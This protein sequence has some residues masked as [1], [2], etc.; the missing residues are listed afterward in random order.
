MLIHNLEEQL[1][2]LKKHAF[3][4]SSQKLHFRNLR[5][6]LIL[7]DNFNTAVMQI[8]YAENFA[9][10]QQREIQSAYFVNNQISIF[11][12]VVWHGNSALFFALI[13]DDLNHDKFSVFANMYEIASFIQYKFPAINCVHIYSDGA[14][15]QFKN[16]FS[17]SAIKIIAALFNF[18]MCWHFFSTSHGKG[19]A[20]GIG[21]TVKSLAWRLMKS[22]TANINNACTFAKALDG[23]CNVNII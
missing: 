4:T 5:D 17:L 2:D 9:I 7:E 14:S 21:A 11:T 16:R 18:K 19:A 3:L 15:S 13:S 8:D 22:E 12:C 6:S 23:K 10:H 20:D 1:P